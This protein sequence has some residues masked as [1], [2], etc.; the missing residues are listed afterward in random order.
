MQRWSKSGV[1][2]ACLGNTLSLST[3]SDTC[4][5]FS[6]A[7][8]STLS[9]PLDICVF[10]PS[11]T[12]EKYISPEIIKLYYCNN[13]SQQRVISHLVY[14]NYRPYILFNKVKSDSNRFN[15]C[16]DCLSIM[17]LTHLWSFL[18]QRHL[19]AEGRQDWCW[20]TTQQVSRI[21]DSHSIQFLAVQKYFLLIAFLLVIS[22]LSYRDICSSKRL[23]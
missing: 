16:D 8:I 3:P 12:L 1:S 9:S 5:A 7:D 15:T 18:I 6:P 23:E 2:G 4:S 11:P 17:N 13:T 10:S 21:L 14:L 20:E 19:E 22:T